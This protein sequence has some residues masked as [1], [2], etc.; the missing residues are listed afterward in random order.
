[1]TMFAR[2][3]RVY[4]TVSI[5]SA[6]PTRLIDE[7]LA[8]ALRDIEDA[9]RAIGA[10]D[11]KTKGTALSHAL[12]IVGELA[13]ALDRSQS[14]ELCA[15]LAALYDFVGTQLTAANVG[16]TAQPLDGAERI[17]RTLRESFDQ[18]ARS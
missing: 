17:L 6:A 13:G 5:E 14:P 10:K 18:A 9:R 3:S 11:V 4:R 8:R 15:N 1:M 2:Q 12:A 16:M 7:L